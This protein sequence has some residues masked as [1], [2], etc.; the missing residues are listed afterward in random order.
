M[1]LS[2]LFP[3]QEFATMLFSMRILAKG[4]AIFFCFYEPISF[5]GGRN[6]SFGGFV[7]DMCRIA[8]QA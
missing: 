1:S 3:F 7:T 2:F 4:H 5:P 6:R 8:G